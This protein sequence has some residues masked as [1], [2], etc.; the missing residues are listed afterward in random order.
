MN[1]EKLEKKLDAA[2]DEVKTIQTQCLKLGNQLEEIK[3][4]IITDDIVRMS[5]QSKWRDNHGHK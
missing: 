4:D 2:I 1:L 5:G 3:G